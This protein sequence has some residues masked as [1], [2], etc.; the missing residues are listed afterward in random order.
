M[1]RLCPLTHI[2]AMTLITAVASGQNYTFT[3][4]VD[5]SGQFSS[6][7]PPAI[8]AGGTAAFYAD[9]DAG[10]SE[11]IYASSGGSVTTIVELGVQGDFSTLV[12]I[13]AAGQVVYRAQFINSPTFE[14]GI[15]IGDGDNRT[16]IVDTLGDE[17]L[18][19]QASPAINSKGTVAFTGTPEATQTGIYVATQP[20]TPI[21]ATTDSDFFFLNSSSINDDGRVVFRGN[22]VGGPGDQGV[23]VGGGGP[24]LTIADNAG[25]FDQFP[26]PAAINSAGT[27]AFH[28]TLDE[29]GGSGIFTSNGGAIN[30]IV[31]TSG[32]F[33]S[34][35]TAAINSGG[36]VA[37]TARFGETGIGIFTGDDPVND[38]VVKEGDPLFDS[39]LATLTSFAHHGINDHGDIA[40]GYELANGL[41]GIAVAMASNAA[42]PGD[43]NDDGLVN[44]ADY[45]VWRNNEG[46]AFE[47][48]NRNPSLMGDIGQ[49]DYDFWVANF[50]N[51]SGSDSSIPYSA[52]RNPKS[53]AVPEP[54]SALLAAIAF[55]LPWGRKK[56]CV[57]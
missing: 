32:E 28:A 9:L 44:A 52:F 23:F 47:M 16:V 4:I 20:F 46:T 5:S 55:L 57:R 8:N 13:D 14:V 24:I 41:R 12:D 18:D 2:A 51:V 26:L 35:G 48:P 38:K 43:Y 25:D 37:F 22:F 7:G 54:A 29:D 34:I 40:F 49:A 15:F 42:L 1:N 50:G 11:G 45:V 27:V 10:Q 17:F 39:T 21:I 33:N 56:I 31:D 30:T 6:F 3:N 53:S 36:T 19:F